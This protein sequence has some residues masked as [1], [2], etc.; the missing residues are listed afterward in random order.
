MNIA[1]K[2]TEFTNKVAFEFKNLNLSKAQIEDRKIIA[3]ILKAYFEE[4]PHQYIGLVCE[5]RLQTKCVEE[6]F[7]E[8]GIDPKNY[9]I[10]KGYLYRLKEEYSMEWIRKFY[11]NSSYAGV[12]VCQIDG[13]INDYVDSSIIHNSS[14]HALKIDVSKDKSRVTK[15]ALRTGLIELTKRF[16]KPLL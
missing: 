3:A 6:V 12:I 1:K 13:I 14:T 11:W 15:R 8:F 10:V 2:I 4:F 9:K 7:K 5:T 16:A